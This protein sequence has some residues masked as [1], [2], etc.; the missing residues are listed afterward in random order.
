M[1]FDKTKIDKQINSLYLKI[2]EK[3]WIIY[4]I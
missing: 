2:S 1:Q 3:F 4:S